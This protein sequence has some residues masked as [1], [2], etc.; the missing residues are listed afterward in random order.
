MQRHVARFW[1]IR[2]AAQT[3][4]G[5]DSI[6][7]GEGGV[8]LDVDAVMTFDPLRLTRPS[9]ERGPMELLSERLIKAAAEGKRQDVDELL[10]DTRVSPDVADCIG[11][12]PLLAASVQLLCCSLS[13]LLVVLRLSSLLIR[14]R[15]VLTAN[16]LAFT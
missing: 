12:T 16:L 5:S 9:S 10:D 15:S 8:E 4:S 14:Y 6:A 7:A 1:K 13:L 2:P 3:G 11:Q